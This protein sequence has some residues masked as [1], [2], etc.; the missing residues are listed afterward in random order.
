VKTN[1]HFWSYRVPFFLEWKVFQTKDVDEIEIHIFCSMTLFFENHA[2]NEIIWKEMVWRGRPQ[3]TSVHAHCM[4]DT[5]G[6]KYT[7]FHCIN[8]CRNLPQCCVIWLHTLPLLFKFVLDNALIFC[9]RDVFLKPSVVEW[10]IRDHL[11]IYV[12][13]NMSSKTVNNGFPLSPWSYKAV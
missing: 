6:Y 5:S 10:V 4:L 9:L 1:V 8:G 13:S 3:L 2:V 12:Q 7:H 11:L